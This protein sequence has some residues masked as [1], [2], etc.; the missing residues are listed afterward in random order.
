M[1]TDFAGLEAEARRHRQSVCGGQRA[2]GSFGK[3]L[4]K[5]LEAFDDRVAEKK[6]AFG[7]ELQPCENNLDGL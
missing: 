7:S 3:F 2:K 5:G 1:D 6:L 4:V